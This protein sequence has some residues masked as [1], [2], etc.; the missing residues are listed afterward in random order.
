MIEKYQVDYYPEIKGI[1]IAEAKAVVHAV[2]EQH[3]SISDT[4]QCY[5]SNA[6]GGVGYAVIYIEPTND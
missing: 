5:A 1:K 4:A 6:A 2:D 3:V